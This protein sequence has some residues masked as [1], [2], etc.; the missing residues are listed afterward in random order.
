MPITFY[1]LCQSLFYAAILYGS[2]LVTGN[3]FGQISRDPMDLFFLCWFVET[4]HESYLLI[5]DWQVKS[6]KDH[7]SVI[8][9]KPLHFCFSC[10]DDRASIRRQRSTS[11]QSCTQKM[12]LKRPFIGDTGEASVHSSL[13][14]DWA[15]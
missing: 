14:E 1:C 9:R 8:L 12:V 11:K 15:H 13:P 5:I 3:I 10:L 2:P 4:Y 6:C 7:S